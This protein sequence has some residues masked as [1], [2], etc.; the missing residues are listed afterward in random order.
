[1]HKQGLEEG[2]GAGEGGKE[3][4]EG[5]VEGL[6]T[7]GSDG[8]VSGKRSSVPCLVENESKYKRN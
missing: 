3:G 5:R 6:S 2:G 4:K 8:R 7:A 1:M